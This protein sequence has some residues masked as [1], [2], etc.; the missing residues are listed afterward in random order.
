M[1]L[2]EDVSLSYIGMCTPSQAD[3]FN[4]DVN[5]VY[6]NHFVLPEL[7]VLGSSGLASP[8]D[9]AYPVASFDIDQSQWESTYHILHDFRVNL[10]NGCLF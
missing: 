6:A 3:L 1:G 7:G 9:F 8:G 10:L 2:L 4:V 5:E